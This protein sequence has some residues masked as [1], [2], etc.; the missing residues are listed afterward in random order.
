MNIEAVSSFFQLYAY[1]SMK[2]GNVQAVGRIQIG[3]KK[4]LT[5]RQ[6][7]LQHGQVWFSQVTNFC[8]NHS[9]SQGIHGF[10]SFQEIKIVS[11][12]VI[13]QIIACLRTNIWQR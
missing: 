11:M 9:I 2:L 1:L 8:S 13:F 7:H 12:F 6:L 10:I 3:C 5:K 4:H